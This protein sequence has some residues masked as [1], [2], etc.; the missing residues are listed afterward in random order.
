MGKPITRAMLALLATMLFFGPSAAQAGVKLFTGAWAVEAF[1]NELT[2][3][4]S[5][6]SE[7]YS[8]F[9]I[10]LGIQC[11][12]KQP[13][14]PFQSTPTNGAGGFARLGG[15]RD[16]ALFCAPWANWQGSGTATRPARGG[17][18]FDSQM[19]AIPPLHRNY[20]F[21]T[22]STP[23]AQ[24]GTYSCQPTSTDGFG[25]PGAVMLGNPINGTWNAN[26]VG[27][28]LG[29]FTFPAAP[30]N[31]GGIRTAGQHGSFPPYRPFAALPSYYYDRAVYKYTYATLRN[32]SGSFDIGGGPGSFS[33]SY[34]MGARKSVVD[35]KGEAQIF[36]K[37]GTARFGGTMRMLGAL[38][39]KGCNLADYSGTACWIG[40]N[41]WRY[42]AIGNRAYYDNSTVSGEPTSNAVVRSGYLATHFAYY[43]HS[44]LMQ[45]STVSVEGARFPWTTG[46]VTVKATG[47][48]THK[49]VH[50]EQGYD[51]RVTNTSSGLGTIQLV[52]PVLTR[53]QS[54]GL[55]FETGGIGI[56]RIKF[57]P[58]PHANAILLAGVA[59]LGVVYRMR[60]G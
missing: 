39:S 17:T 4:T 14:C 59:L 57:V 36:V 60:R 50:Y 44:G 45:V 48:G 10:P 11:N 3:A 54:A 34:T 33:L 42:D 47:R 55:D 2:G 38:T 15:S 8:R 7:F 13:R 12:P 53:W 25:G 46:K 56:L 6:E 35:G 28:A 58:E 32:D 24:P 30:V 43:Y 49:T 26:T 1:G 27:G 9:V 40:E 52:T 31:G 21:F 51:N 22:A 20:G 5:G 18:S 37:A 16:Q 19:R 23:S 29:G 41:N